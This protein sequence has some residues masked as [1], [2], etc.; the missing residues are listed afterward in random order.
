MQKK[1]WVL[2]L[3]TMVLVLAAC[4]DDSDVDEAAEGDSAAD[5]GGRDLVIGMINEAVSLDPHV[6]NDIPSAQ[7]RT[8]IFDT[9]VE[10]NVDMEFGEGLATSFE[11]DGDKWTLNLKEDVTFH[12]GSEFTAADVEATLDRVMDPSVGSSVAFMFEM[13]N[14]IEIVND[15]EIVLTTDYPFTPLPSHLAHNTAGILSKEVIDE[16]YQNALDEAGSDVTLEEYY[17]LREEGGEEFEAV[18]QEIGSHV[19]AVITEK[20]DGTGHLKLQE[21]IPGNEIVLEKF[22]EFHGGER[23]FNTVTYRVIPENS[24]R[25]AELETGGI[26]ITDNVDT[27]AMDRVR[28]HNDTDIID[29]DGLSMTYVAFNYEKEPFD[30]ENVRKAISHAIDREQ[31]ISGVLND[32]GIHAKNHISPSVFA[33]NAD[34]EEVP[35]DI[36]LAKEYM[37]DSS[38][39]DGFDTV[40]WTSD[41]EQNRDIALI[42]QESLSELGI[43]VEIEQY[44]HGAFLEMADQGDH[45]MFMLQWITVTGDPNYGLY[46]MFHTDSVGSGNRWNYSNPELDGYLEEGQKTS[47]EGE[48]EAAYATAQEILMEDL[49][50]TPLYYGELGIGVNNTLVEGVELDPVG[51]VRI[52]NVTFPE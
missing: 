11:Q 1:L 27:E 52:E 21:R 42:I 37:A 35:Y 3:F 29:Q 46:P 6:S 18:S 40:I 10:Q 43:N 31:I 20:P 48:R 4:T 47:E 12:N 2:M 44:E 38:V 51:I 8:Q 41:S 19:G 25:L 50:I 45:D 34:M 16:D 32:R 49:P 28:E 22:E 14:D 7:L 36:E 5:S 23:E 9:L 33:H 30:D 24:A 17:E 15:H 26:G 39:P 13:I